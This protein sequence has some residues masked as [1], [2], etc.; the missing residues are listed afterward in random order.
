MPALRR[1]FFSASLALL[2]AASAAPAAIAVP[3]GWLGV[4]LNTAAGGPLSVEEVLDGGPAAKAG[5]KPGDVIASW[6]GAKVASLEDLRAFLEKT[7]AGDEGLLGL[8]RGDQEVFAKV[9]LGDREKAMQEMDEAEEEE[10]AEM[11][12]RELVILEDATGQEPEVEVRPAHRPGSTYVGIQL[13]QREGAVAVHGVVAG[14]PAQRIGIGVGEV[15]RSIDGQAVTTAEEVVKA[16]QAKKPGERIE[17]KTTKTVGEEIS[18]FSYVF[19]VGAAPAA[20]PA[21][22]TAPMRLRVAPRVPGAA[23]PLE[24]R[25][26]EVAPGTAR[27]EAHAHEMAALREELA[28]L[29]AEMA[30]MKALLKEIDARLKR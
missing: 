3:H 30:E 29:R 7:K 17:I 2:L 28:R 10:I 27:P 13:E 18:E 22:P 9:V 5:V 23:T 19:P 11:L 14:S 8:R 26:I 1:S 25:V 15:I 16:V 6:N 12:P 24:P 4:T 20:A 21:A